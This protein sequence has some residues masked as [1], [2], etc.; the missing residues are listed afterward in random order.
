MRYQGEPVVAVVADDRY[1]A[2]DAA[3][4]VQVEYDPL[5]VVDNFDDARADKTI[6]HE[7]VGTNTL[8]HKVFNFGDVDEDFAEAD[9]V[10]EEEFDFDRFTA[11]PIETFR[12]LADYDDVRGVLTIWSNFIQRADSTA[13]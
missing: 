8:W 6:L 13:R 7:E 9:L 11:S 3:E 10:V 4:L 2:E 5:P 1:S 12:C